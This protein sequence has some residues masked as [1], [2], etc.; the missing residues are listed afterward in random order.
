MDENIATCFSKIRSWNGFTE[1]IKGIADSLTAPLFRGQGNIFRSAGVTNSG[2]R[3]EPSFYRYK[4]YVRPKFKIF[5]NKILADPTCK[6]VIK[7]TIGKDIDRNALIGLM[8]HLDLPTPLLDWSKSP[9][10]AAY[11]AFMYPLKEA[12]KVTIFLLDQ[13]S[14]LNNANQ[15]TSRDL[16]ILK[17]EKLD[18]LIER[19]KAQDSV[20]IYSNNE[21]VYG[22]LLGDEDEGRERFLSYCELPIKDQSAALRS[23]EEMGV[24]EKH[25]FPDRKIVKELAN[26][27]Y[28]KFSIHME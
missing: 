5:L 8:R 24:S 15:L 27:L 16:R 11:F 14:W 23:L 3:L 7:K 4:K 10:V 17:L 21:G 26:E 2:W 19:Q 6:L 28:K 1:R 20:Y 9:F 13:H 18:H 22:E 12:K 25:M